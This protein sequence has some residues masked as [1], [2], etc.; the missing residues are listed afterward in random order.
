M[1]KTQD[2]CERERSAMY[3]H[4][5]FTILSQQIVSGKS[6]LVVIWTHHWNYFFALVKANNNMLLKIYCNIVM[7]IAFLKKL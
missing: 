2:F 7:D 6:L 5:I 4:D 1:F 3:I